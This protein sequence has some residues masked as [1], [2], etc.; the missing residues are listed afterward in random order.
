MVSPH[1]FPTRF[2]GVFLLDILKNEEQGLNE[3]NMEQIDQ[4]GVLEIIT[5]VIN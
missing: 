1:I 5:E 2:R 3:A 4:G